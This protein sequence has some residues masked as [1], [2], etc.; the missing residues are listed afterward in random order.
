MPNSPSPTGNAERN[1]ILKLEGVCVALAASRK[2]M[3]RNIS[4]S[5]RPGEIFGLAGESGSG[6]TLLMRTIF[7]LHDD[8]FVEKGR[9]TF[10]NTEFSS[11]EHRR[12]VRKL[13]GRE[14]GFVPQD[15]FS[16]LNPTMRI[17]RQIR[18]ALYLGKGISPK[19]AEAG[20]TTLELLK[21]VGISEPATAV[22]QYPDQFSG[23]MRQRIVI[24]IALS[25]EPSILVADEPTTALDAYTQRRIINLIIERSRN[26]NLA[27]I[28]ISHNLELLRKNVD[29]IAVMYGGQ[30]FNILASDEI[31]SSASHP[32]T[33]ALFKCIPR[34]D[35]NLADIQ[36]IPGEPLSAGYGAAGCAFSSRCG[37]RRDICDTS[38]IPVNASLEQEF[39]ACLVRA[40]RRP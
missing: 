11:S 9:M 39:D 1:A 40:G 5:V 28:L 38:E 10:K 27:V 20:K 15:P 26:R 17:G 34:K 25:Q 3:V 35:M 12:R 6:K 33:E 16:S 22:G 8:A 29:R 31:G 37:L 21:E 36:S 13:L 4:F 14:I 2:T 19:S 23:G 7:G 24:A 32:Y 30:L 18:E